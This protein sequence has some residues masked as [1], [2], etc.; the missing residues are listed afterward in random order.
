M[1]SVRGD[2]NLEPEGRPG[3][4]YVS[5]VRRLPLTFTAALLAFGCGDDGTQTPEGSSGSTGT[6]PTPM[7]TTDVTPGSTSEPGS[8]SDATTTGLDSTTGPVVECGNGVVEDDEECDDENLENDDACYANCTLPY[9]ILWTETH[10]EGDADFGNHVVFDAEGNIYVVGSVQVPGQGYDLWLRQYMP[11]GSAGW[12]YTYNGADSE[13]DVG[14]QIAWHQS[15]DLLVVG[16]TE[17]TATED[18]ILVM[19]LDIA[20]Q[21]PVWTDIYAGMGM[22]PDPIDATDLGNS[23]FGAANG[24]VLVGGTERV[25]GQ[26][27]D[28]WLRRYDADGVEIWTQSFNN[29][30]YNGSD[31]SDSVLEDSTGDIYLV[32]ATEVAQSVFET[33]V[34]KYDSDGVEIWTQQLAD[35]QMFEAQ[36]DS[37]D[38]LVM[39]GYVSTGGGDLWAGK[40]DPD[41]GLLGIT[42]YDGPSGLFDTAQGVAIDAAGD[43]YLAGSITIIGEQSNVWVGRYQSE[44][45]MRWWSSSYGNEESTLADEARSVAVSDDGT[46]VA[47]VGFESVIGEDTNIWVRMYQNNPLPR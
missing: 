34:R 1:D 38:N 43:I 8:T 11:D 37:M 6:E 9:E 33:W 22:G 31:V 24:D 27:Y 28:V 40:Y 39:A 19:R 12:T 13:D 29:T 18:D 46:R 36:L 14:R 47:V 32:G 21:T 44:L 3:G 35:V 26:E 41:F 20:T 4:W 17:G 16:N 10:D 2:R 23:I 5:V 30:D 45:D 15:G 25:D 7:T 42:S